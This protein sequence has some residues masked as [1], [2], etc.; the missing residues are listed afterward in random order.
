VRIVR[1]RPHEAESEPV[2]RRQSPAPRAPIPAKPCRG[3]GKRGVRAV[4]AAAPPDPEFERELRLR[5]QQKR[6]NGEHEERWDE[7]V[8]DARVEA[9]AARDGAAVG[10]GEVV[11]VQGFAA[12]DARRIH[13][14]TVMRKIRGR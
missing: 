2:A 6:D 11:S 5:Q 14:D 12:T 4:A 3:C 10:A 1:R 13:A 8:A 7:Q 9:P